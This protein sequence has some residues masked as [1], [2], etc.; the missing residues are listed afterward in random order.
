MK[1][2]LLFLLILAPVKNLAAGPASSPQLIE[3]G[4][5]AFEV[6][7][8]VCHGSGGKGD[9]PAGLSMNPKPRNL[10]TDAFKA[11]SAPD[12]IFSTV[13]NGLKGTNMVG[14]PTLTEQDRWGL[15]YYILSLRSK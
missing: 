10:V 2:A 12:Q 13:T 1:Y 15:V 8:M 5:K 11:G 9:G 3:K 7:C 4:K 6:N 14:F